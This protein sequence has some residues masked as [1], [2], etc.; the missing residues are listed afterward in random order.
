VAKLDEAVKEELTAAGVQAAQAKA[1][2]RG[3]FEG[4]LRSLRK[5]GNLE[6]FYVPH[7][8]RILDYS[9]SLLFNDVVNYLRTAGF[10]GD[11]CSL[12]TSRPGGPDGPEEPDRIRKG[13]RPLHRPAGLRQYRT[14]FLFV[15]P[16][17]APASLGR[18][19]LRMGRRR[20]HG[21]C[22]A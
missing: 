22:A 21:D 16:D 4:H 15:R 19:V 20:P 3:E 5:D 14:Q 18:P 17:N 10:A 1:L 6:P 12:T 11:T 8:T 7:D 13:V 2:A 9:R